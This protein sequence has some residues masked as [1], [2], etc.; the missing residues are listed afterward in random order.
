MNTPRIMH[1]VES[2]QDA[3]RVVLPTGKSRAEVSHHFG[4]A[5]PL[6]VR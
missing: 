1:S 4:V 2:E 3:I 5:P 6:V